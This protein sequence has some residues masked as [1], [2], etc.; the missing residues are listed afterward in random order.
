MA[1]KPDDYCSGYRDSACVDHM[2]SKD[3]HLLYGVVCAE[4]WSTLL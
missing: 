2:G 3:S 4:A 1:V